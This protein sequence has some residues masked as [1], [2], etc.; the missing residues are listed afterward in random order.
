MLCFLIYLALA[1]NEDGQ[2]RTMTQV[3]N[4]LIARYSTRFTITDTKEQDGYYAFSYLDT[5]NGDAER[6]VFVLDIDTYLDP[7]LIKNERPSKEDLTTIFFDQ[8]NY[9]SFDLFKRG[10]KLE[11]LISK[12]KRDE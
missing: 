4:I 2:A 6:F 9:A 12:L 1:E 10:V 8:L 3:A 11:F 5:T 7:E